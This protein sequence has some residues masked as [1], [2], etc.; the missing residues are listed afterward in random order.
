[1][2]MNIT[3]PF[4]I[5]FTALEPNKEM[6]D[7]CRTALINKGLNVC[8]DEENLSFSLGHEIREIEAI[9]SSLAL[10]HLFSSEL[11]LLARP[12]VLTRNSKKPR[13]FSIEQSMSDSFTE[14]V[15]K[16]IDCAKTWMRSQCPLRTTIFTPIK[17]PTEL[18]ASHD[19]LIIGETHDDP[20]ARGW[21]IRNMP[22]LKITTLFLE[23]FCYDS[24]QKQLDAYRTSEDS[25]MQEPLN[26][27][28]EDLDR[29]FR[30]HGFKELLIA[31]KKA[32][33]RIVGLDTTL[34]YSAGV[35][36]KMGAIDSEKRYLAMNYVAVE[37]IRKEKCGKYIALTGNGH[38]ASVHPQ[39]PG[40]AELLFQPSI[41]IET[42]I[43]EKASL[44]LNVKNLH[45]QISQVSVFLEEAAVL[46]RSTKSRKTEIE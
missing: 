5:T 26:T 38:V 46:H 44:T 31:A 21:L 32:N 2:H 20:A 7:K 27:F 11:S 29:G 42:G 24:F 15:N 6:F 1:M 41:V 39:I 22:A 13:R 45:N 9:I 33:V 19:G 18:F 17:C 37:I 25:V 36:R 40:I 35:D 3:E 8:F 43:K 30:S 23:H 28:V 4:I 10:S 16:L 14:S 34:S 12:L